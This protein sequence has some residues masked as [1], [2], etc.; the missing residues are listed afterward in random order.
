[1]EPIVLHKLPEGIIRINSGGFED[2][3]THTCDSLRC[4][5][6]SQRKTKFLWP[7]QI[8]TKIFWHFP[9]FSGLTKFPDNSWFSQLVSILCLPHFLTTFTWFVTRRVME[10]S[11]PNWFTMLHS[12]KSTVPV[13]EARDLWRAFQFKLT[14]DTLSQICKRFEIWGDEP[15]EAKRNCWHKPKAMWCKDWER[16]DSYSTLQSH[17]CPDLSQNFSCRDRTGLYLTL[18]DPAKQFMKQGNL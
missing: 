2:C 5:L 1:M 18:R 10:A 17:H 11:R 15:D 12:K 7:A 13:P 8:C 4:I 16:Q 14:C 3:V 6:L 9:T